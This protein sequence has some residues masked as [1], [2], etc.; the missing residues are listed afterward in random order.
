MSQQS[1]DTMNQLKGESQFDVRRFRPNLLVDIPDTD[2]PFP[3]QAWV[4]KTL[5]IGSVMLKID[6]TCPRCAMTTHGFDDLPQ[7]AQIMRKLVANSEGNLGIYASVVQAGR[8]TA[9]DSV[10]VV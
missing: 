1:L 2:H 10:S 9:G 7:D 3:E 6:T 8:V 4:G 5:S